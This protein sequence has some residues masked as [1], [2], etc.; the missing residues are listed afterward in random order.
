MKAFDYRIS[1]VL[2]LLFILSIF[3]RL[4]N[5]NRPLSTNYEWVT[6]HTLVTLKIWK[7]E[8]IWQHRFTPIYTYSNPND[9]YIK[10]PI[11]GI[12]DSKGNYYY[13]SY[14]PFSFIFAF[15]F[16]NYTN[17]NL[18]PLPLQILNLAIHFFCS[19][20][21]YLIVCFTTHRITSR[22]NPAALLGY[23]IYLFSP[24]GL[25]NH[26]NVYF[27]DILVQLFFLLSILL[28]LYYFKNKGT[29][30]LHFFIL[31]HLSLFMMMYTEWIGFLFSLTFLLMPLFFKFPR[32]IL[33]RHIISTL[34]TSSLVVLLIIIQYSSISNIPDFIETLTSRYHE[35]SGQFGQTPLY[36][37]DAHF[38]LLKMYLRNYFPYLII[39]LFS[40]ILV[41]SF[42]LSL[43]ASH[44]KEIKHIFT[45]CLIPIIGHHLLLF[46]FTIVHELSLLKSSIF[47]SILTGWLAGCLTDKFSNPV[48]NLEKYLF[49]FVSISMICLGIYFYYSHIIIPDEYMSL[50]LGAQIAETSS[51]ED[52]IFF[53]SSKTQGD[54]LIQAPENF[55][56]APQIQ[57]YAGRC[58]QVVSNLDDA[59]D[60]LLQ[61]KKKQGVVY[62]IDNP[63]LKIESVSRISIADSVHVS[64]P[65]PQNGK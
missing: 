33:R 56:I 42:G 26:S 16:L 23:C 35:R 46:E 28:A 9:H 44:T 63:F 14:P 48:H 5:I 51:E 61:Y 49:G 52:T 31:V 8:G 32:T 54:F 30:K 29:V 41:F 50:R 21:V 22:T 39:I 11:S 57:Y 1:S 45:L 55:V 36:R 60:H 37:I 59:Y 27:A 15:L 20:L 19:L 34:S 40:I 10:C 25:W 4:P 62:Q 12:S 17:S 3:I 13:I 58:I 65:S 18:S 53:R 6:A 38:F 47:I 43:K 2:L 64:S 7:E 24:L